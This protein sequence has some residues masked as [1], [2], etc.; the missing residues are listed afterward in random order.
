MLHA[1]AVCAIAAVAVACSSDEEITEKQSGV[2]ETIT[3]TASQ[4]GNEA[5]SRLAFTTQGKAYWHAADKIG[6]WS[7][8]EKKFNSFS[9]LD[10]A[11]TSTASFRGDVIE[12]VGKYAVYPYNENHQLSGSTLTYYLPN[13]YTYTSVDQTFFPDDNNGNSFGAPMCGLV[14]DDNTVSFKHLGGVLCIQIDK[15]PAESGTVKVTAASNQLC[16][17]F[18]AALTDNAPE[19]KTSQATSNKSVTFKY[20]GATTDKAGVFY[21]PVATGNYS[22]TIVVSGNKQSSTTTTEVEMT[23]NRLQVVKVT[24][25]YSADAEILGYYAFKATTAAEIA[26]LTEDDFT[27]ITE[28][29]LMITPTSDMDGTMPVVVTNNSVPKFTKQDKSTNAWSDEVSMY[30]GSDKT[31]TSKTINGTNY[32]LYRLA[33][34]IDYSVT[35]SI[36]ITL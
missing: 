11:G 28:S 32:T 13:S 20:S 2:K 36:K 21:L 22:L 7:T 8:G 12:G 4:P 34:K 10:G 16:G 1:V 14:S 23:R 19:I 3:L 30:A 15:M 5:T 31:G 6:V 9:L 17:T 25:N 24:T 29:P 27:A 18:T 33:G 26:T 35:S